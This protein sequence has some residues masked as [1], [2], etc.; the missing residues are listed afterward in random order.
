M[1]I[2]QKTIE[3]FEKLRRQSEELLQ[4][5][6]N[7]FAERPGDIFELIHELRIHQTELEIQNEE[8]QRAQ[9][10]ISD[11]HLKYE[12]LYE[13]APCAYLTLNPKGII[14]QAN[15]MAVKLLD[16]ERKYLL[17][18]GF[19]QYIENGFNNDYLKARKTAGETGI[20]QI[21]ELRLKNKKDKPK[22]IQADIEAVRDEKEH[23]HQWRVI[24]FD[25]TSQK[26]TKEAYRQK[27]IEMEAMYNAT[28][29]LLEEEDFRTISRNLFNICQELTG[30]KAGYVALLS[31]NRTEN[32]I[33]FLE[34]GGLSSH[35]NTELSMTLSGFKA[36]VFKTGKVMFDNDFSNSKWMQYIPEGHI[37]LTNVLFGPIKNNGKTVGLICLANKGTLFNANDARAVNALSELASIALKQSITRQSL[38][39]SQLQLVQSQKMEAVGTLAAGIAHDF[40]NLLCV[41]MGNASYALQLSEDNDEIKEALIDLERGAEKAKKLIQQMLTFAKG[42]APLCK[43]LNVN[44]N[45]KET[46]DLVLRGS[47]S[48]VKF[49]LLESIWSIEADNNQLYQAFGNLL[50]NADQ[51]MPEGGFIHITTQNEYINDGKL[52]PPLKPG[53]YVSIIVKDDGV[54]IND[55]NLSKV[56][57][58]FYTTKNK[59][60]GLGLTTTFSI[61]NRH[62]G[63][64][65][66]ASTFGEGTTFTIYLPAANNVSNR[67]YSSKDKVDH[68]GQGKILIMDDE[69]DML[70]MARRMLGRMGYDTVFAKDGAEAI[71]L[72]RNTF[73]SKE[74]FDLVILD[75]T[76]PGGMGG[77]KTIPELLKIDPKVKAVVSSG[78]YTD[79][80]MA[81][82]E[83]YGFIG[84]V[85][86][87]YSIDQMAE[88]LDIIF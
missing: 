16:I 32:E 54:G 63:N 5:R 61:I 2:K 28:K 20:K 3:K 4:M 23:V 68:K 29:L 22:W 31:E 49:N 7:M 53:R 21:I 8:L 70:K 33:L 77:A 17:R 83:D 34:T 1:S 88:L 27:A 65:S 46:A 26:E 30:A 40:N 36:E 67:S 9:Q 80:V 15:L 64:I 35:V 87:P 62:G 43:P 39:E 19:S 75:L 11:L 38:K 18:S 66:V 6:P 51:A 41:I 56:F 14:T 44:K 79:P 48:T 74:P 84:V 78:Y 57:D 82:Y 59:G 47:A 10:E 13:F 76:V 69:A 24:I 25:I 72:Y 86:K 55:K 71:N 12:N 45:I 60:H 42:G 81:N 50:I 85:P 58:P 37:E 73:Q 52:S